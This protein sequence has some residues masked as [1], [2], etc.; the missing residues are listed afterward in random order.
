MLRRIVQTDGGN[1]A[2]LLVRLALGIVMFPHGAQQMLGWYGGYGFQGT[3]SYFTG[4]MHVPAVLAFLAIQAEFLGSLGLITGFLT[5]IAAFGIFCN[6]AV[7]VV[8]VHCHVGFFM[9]WFGQQ[10]GEG[11][12]YHILA[13]AMAIALMMRGGGAASV[14]AAWGRK[15]S[16]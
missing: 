6:M 15:M 12:E 2:A 10:Q 16:F 8:M 4:T 3:M 9:N 14:D 1:M 7:A 13:I 5:R 11:F